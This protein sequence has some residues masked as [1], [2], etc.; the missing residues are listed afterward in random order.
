MSIKN[1]QTFQNQATANYFTLEMGAIR[2]S[3]TLVTTNKTTRRHI[4]EDDDHRHIHRC[5]DLKSQIDELHYDK[6]LF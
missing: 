3:E 6:I 4:P 5:E 2:S 1:T